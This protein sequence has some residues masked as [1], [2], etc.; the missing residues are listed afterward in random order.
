MQQRSPEWYAARVGKLTASRMNDAV[1]VLKKGG[2]SQA[3]INYRL[4]LATERL[5]GV[6]IEK[7]TNSAMQWGIDNEPKAREE[8]ELFNG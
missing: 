5:T 1:D 6:L 3:R 4:E 2:E 8:F 7:Y